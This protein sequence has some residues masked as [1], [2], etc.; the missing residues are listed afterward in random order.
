MPIDLMIQLIS[1]ALG[2]NTAAA[3]NKS[4]S[5]GRITNAVLGLIGGCV[6]G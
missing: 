2:G 1:G 5:M 4:N 6:V 3:A